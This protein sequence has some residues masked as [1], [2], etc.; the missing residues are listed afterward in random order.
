M[1]ELKPT[2]AFTRYGLAMEYRNTGD[3]EGA[4]TEFRAIMENNPDYSPA[5]FHGG[6]TLERMGQVEEA[7]EVYRKGVEVTVKIG[8][9]HARSEMQGALDMLD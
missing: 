3:L 2:D 8:N 1:V 9:E 7:R 4:M 5:Y 6:Q